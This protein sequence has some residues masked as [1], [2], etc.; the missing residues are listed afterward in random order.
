MGKRGTDGPGAA[1]PPPNHRPTQGSPSER[2]LGSRA[3]MRFS[4]NRS[5]QP[6]GR[7]PKILCSLL[8][9]PVRSLIGWN[10]DGVWNQF[11]SPPRVARMR[12]T[13]G[14]GTKRRWREDKGLYQRGHGSQFNNFGRRLMD[15]GP[16]EPSTGKLSALNDGHQSR[17][18]MTDWIWNGGGGSGAC[19]K[20]SWCCG[21]SCCLSRCWLNSW[22][23]A[24]YHPACHPIP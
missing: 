7:V 1:P 12:A 14:F 23:H 11:F 9:I 13:L 15:H 19:L 18:R 3:G 5:I 22:N 10:S 2:R 4:K 24:P 8:A 21:E 17:S 6:R 16:W 20:E